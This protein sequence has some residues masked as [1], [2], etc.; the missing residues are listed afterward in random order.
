MEDIV[1][2]PLIRSMIA[3]GRL[4]LMRE[5]HVWGG[6]GTGVVCAA[7]GERITKTEVGI[8]TSNGALDEVN[9]LQLHVHCFHVWVSETRGLEA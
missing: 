2:R 4:P 1:L 5:S 8:E 6:P 3:E 9:A 7:C